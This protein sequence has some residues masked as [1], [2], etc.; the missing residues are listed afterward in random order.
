MKKMS[1]K[2]L[3]NILCETI[4]EKISSKPI[5]ESYD[6]HLTYMLENYYFQ[7]YKYMRTLH[8]SL[9]LTGWHTRSDCIQEVFH[10]YCSACQTAGTFP[11]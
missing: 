3:K 6:T 10:A 7:G 1:T 5:S 9:Y 4:E 2:N 11:H 8:D